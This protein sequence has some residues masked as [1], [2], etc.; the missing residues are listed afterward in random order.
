MSGGSTG[1]LRDGLIGVSIGRID[2]LRWIGEDIYTLRCRRTGKL[3]MWPL[4]QSVNATSVHSISRSLQL[5]IFPRF[6]LAM[7]A[8]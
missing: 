6:F 8:P 3:F 1:G 7:G 4:N 5:A 2:S